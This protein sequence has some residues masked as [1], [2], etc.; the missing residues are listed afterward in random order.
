MLSMFNVRSVSCFKACN[1][2]CVTESRS[3]W[4]EGVRLTVRDLAIL[5]LTASFLPL[6]I[7]GKNNDIIFLRLTVKN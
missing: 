6:R 5:W 7:K 3:Q 1:I 2:T 4:S